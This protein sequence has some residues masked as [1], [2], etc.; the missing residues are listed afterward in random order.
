MSKSYPQLKITGVA[1]PDRITWIQRCFAGHGTVWEANVM[2]TWI[3]LYEAYRGKSAFITISIRTKDKTHNSRLDFK[4]YMHYN[5][6]QLKSKARKLL[7][8][9]FN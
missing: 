1:V 3:Y 4:K 6:H 5:K 7:L 2:N 9:I 8:E